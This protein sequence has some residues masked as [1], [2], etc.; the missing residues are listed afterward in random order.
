MHY[1]T[2]IVVY[3]DGGEDDWLVVVFLSNIVTFFGFV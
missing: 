2:L 1:N 3:D